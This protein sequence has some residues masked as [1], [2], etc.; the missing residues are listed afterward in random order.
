M[1]WGANTGIFSAAIN[2]PYFPQA[3]KGPFYR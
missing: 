2:V 1:W 3:A